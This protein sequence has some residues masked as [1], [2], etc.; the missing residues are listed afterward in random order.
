MTQEEI[1]K[2][3]NELDVERIKLIGKLELLQEQAKEA[4]VEPS[5]AQ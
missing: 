3:I 2:R 1:I 5:P 4:K